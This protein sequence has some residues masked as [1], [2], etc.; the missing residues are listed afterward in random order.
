MTA[1]KRSFKPAWSKTRRKRHQHAVGRTRASASAWVDPDDA[2]ELTQDMAERADLYHGD[3]LSRRSSCA[4]TP[5]WSSTFAPPAPA[6][7]RGSTTPCAAPPNSRRV[8]EA[9]R[10]G[11]GTKAKPAIDGRFRACVASTARRATGLRRPSA[12]HV[13]RCAVCSAIAR[14]KVRSES[15][16]LPRAPS[17][18]A[19]MQ[20]FP[21]PI[22]FVCH[23]PQQK[24]G[25][26][27]RANRRARHHR[28]VARGPRRSTARGRKSEAHCALAHS[29]REQ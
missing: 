9:P 20:I 22:T 25:N 6:G 14:C 7:R 5:M 1:R 4:S 23:K 18:A 3:K 8:C 10:G 13:A 2:P 12:H 29:K 16:R 19:K 26:G 28:R 27:D 11:C 24:S 15:A 17:Y 21:R